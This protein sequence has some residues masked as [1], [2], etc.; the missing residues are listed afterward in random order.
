MPA[1]TC[2]EMRAE[3]KKPSA[4]ATSTK[5]GIELQR[6]EERRHHVVPEEDL[7]QQ[8]DVAEQL[9]PGV[10]QPDQRLLGVVR[11]MPI[12]EP[13]TSATTRAS[14]ATDSVQP[15]ADNIQCR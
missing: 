7:H 2:S 4:S 12:S 13:T 1:R 5:L 8:R 11:K 6:R 14:S 9:G 3:V 10:A 15:Q